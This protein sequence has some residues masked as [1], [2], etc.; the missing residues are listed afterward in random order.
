MRTIEL[1][2]FG[3]G[4]SVIDKL[5]ELGYDELTEV[6]RLAIESG[7]FENRSILVSAPTNTGKTFIGELAILVASTRKV[8]PKSFFL[9]PLKALA[10]EKFE[11]FQTKYA[12]WG[13]RIAISTHDRTEF[14]DELAEY[15]VVI[16]TYEKF[17]ALLIRRPALLGEVGL[18]IIDE[19]Q[20][21]GDESRGLQIEALLTTLL[22]SPNRPQIIGLSA[23]IPNASDMANWLEATLVETNK[24]DVELRE[25][26]LFIGK[27]PI[28]FLGNHLENGDFI[29]R[30]F[31]TEKIGVE[32]K[33]N[34][35]TVAQISELSKS[36]QSLIFVD[37][38]RN[39][40]NIALKV[41]SGLPATSETNAFIEELDSRVEATP[42]TRILKRTLQ[43]G[44]AF[45]HAG[46]LPEE[47][48]IIEDGFRNGQI[49]VV[50]ATTTLGAGV[51]TPAKN[52]ALLSHQ[53][54]DKR[55]ILTRD[56]KNMVGRAGR[57]RAKDNFGR[58]VLFAGSEKEIEM[59]WK[60]YVIAK[61]E[62]VKSQIPSG[63]RLDCSMLGLLTSGVCSTI[64]ELM[65]F[66][67]KTFYGYIF[68]KK[69][70]KDIQ[71]Q[72]DTAI[73]Q[74]I[75][76]LKKNGFIEVKND[77]V[78]VTELG[79]RCAEE[80]LSPDT[81]LL[82]YETLRRFEDSIKQTKEFDKLAEG[83]IHL[84]CCS[85]DATPSLL[86]SP[87][88]VPEIEE[89]Q[90]IWK[91]SRDSFF[92]EPNQ[93]LFLKSLRTTRML[94]RWIDGVLF[95]ELYGYAPHGII[96]RDAENISWILKGLSRLTEK[97][98]FDFGTEFQEFIRILADRVYYGVPSDAVPI[99]KLRIPAVHRNRAIRLAKAG[100][101]TIDDLINASIGQLI[102][103]NGIGE[104]LAL[105]IK[106]YV[107]N[108]IE[109]NVTR[110]RQRQLRMAQQL[111]KS[112]VIIEQLYQTKDDVFSR[113]CIE[114]LKTHI[115]L[116]AIF[117]GDAGEHEVDG[118]VTTPEGKIAI[119]GKRK[120][121]KGNVSAKEAE[122]VLG[123]GARHNPIANVTI[124]YPDFV[125]EAK[126]NAPH[127]K[128]TLIKVS[129]LGE[130]L[131]KFWEG[132]LSKEDVLGIMKS[133]KY[134][135]SLSGY[136]REN[137]LK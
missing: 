121:E 71:E 77:K 39:A 43:N 126:R 26:I 117:I 9:V 134:I 16:A 74:V 125:E 8:A 123:K 2:K 21:L 44:V 58:S 105:R 96:K 30:E 137:R 3:I 82:F 101:K 100:F 38:Q 57:F 68:Y 17:N 40:E 25:G 13:L 113:V 15:D 92:Y 98:L 51:N 87:R 10:E 67:K 1:E 114:L 28:S 79:R 76:K 72:F 5:I 37:T 59:L 95:S 12:K 45:H 85:P 102:S 42:S 78:S 49:R 4:R 84:S 83:F 69:A 19:L 32:Q 97:P 129:V 128:I 62:P 18:V 107:E 7:L 120:K 14:D 89:L 36:E 60:E 127:A 80:L 111:G 52:V 124:G 22:I 109:D 54:Y 115:G 47:R 119:E 50:C 106:E 31:N 81:I 136:E 27:D 133:G 122:E 6:Q 46:L 66:L 53:T 23:T 33:L 70:T 63:R 65:S 132:K 112:S 103:V 131:I 56:Y 88:S 108:F 20:N 75:F 135:S 35:N 94:M 34:I 11:D 93:D 64:E 91:V 104:K 48:G 61:P 130:I 116:D 41:A 86:F 29:Y 99:M 90:A 24:R 110:S 73:R 118:L 55:N